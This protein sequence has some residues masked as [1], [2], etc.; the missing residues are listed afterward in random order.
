MPTQSADRIARSSVAHLVQGPELRTIFLGFNLARDELS[1][2]DAKG[3]NPFRDRRVRQAFAQ[4]IDEDTIKAKVMRGFARPAGLLVGPGISGYDAALDTRPIFDPGAAKALLAES[5]YPNGFSL[6]M[7]CPN[8]RYVNDEAICDAVVAMLAKV[9]VKVKLDAETR[10]KVFGKLLLPE[11]RS[12]FFLL[13]WSAPTY[14]A[15]NPLVNLA[16]TRNRDAHRG[17]ANFTGYSNPA[18]DTLLTRIGETFAVPERTELL[19]QALAMVRDDLAYLPLH[20]QQLVWAAR[21][22][23]ELVQRAD[24]TFPLRYVVVK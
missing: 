8:D 23:V 16:A 3:R 9:G 24:G 17:D 14:D 11:Y 12:S 7:D 19:H 15:L 10:G 4:A 2:S 5:G 21:N 6:G 1:D 13:G 18:L 22:N 20:Q